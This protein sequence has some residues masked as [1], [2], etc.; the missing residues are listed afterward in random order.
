MKIMNSTQNQRLIMLKA[1]DFQAKML[2]FQTFLR[3]RKKAH[4][5]RNS[6]LPFFGNPSL[7]IVF[8]DRN[9]RVFEIGT[10]R[11][12]FPPDFGFS[13]WLK[14]DVWLQPWLTTHVYYPIPACPISLLVIWPAARVRGLYLRQLMNGYITRKATPTGVKRKQARAAA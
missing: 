3:R 5:F 11:K 7:Q 6:P 9:Q 4:K 10:I 8:Q 12:L 2:H 13:P 14:G 1:L